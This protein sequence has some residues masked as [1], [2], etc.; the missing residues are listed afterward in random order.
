MRGSWVNPPPGTVPSG[1]DLDVAN[2]ALLRSCRAVSLGGS[3]RP[4]ASFPGGV[5]GDAGK[6]LLGR[7]RRPGRGPAPGGTASSA[8]RAFARRSRQSREHQR[9][10]PM[11]RTTRRIGSGSPLGQVSEIARDHLAAGRVERARYVGNSSSTEEC[12]VAVGEEE[13][14]PAAGMVAVGLVDLGVRCRRARPARRSGRG[15]CRGRSRSASAD[16]VVSPGQDRAGNRADQVASPSWCD[17][18]PTAMVCDGAVGDISG[19]GL[20]LRKKPFA[21]RP[22]L[23][24]PAIPT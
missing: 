14:H 4:R 11:L 20:L 12:D 15:S 8:R 22:R 23:A 16:V 1:R 9:A 13:V 21:V 19:A 3:G 2:L 7:L 10:P 6:L 5:E 17:R 18:S 24:E